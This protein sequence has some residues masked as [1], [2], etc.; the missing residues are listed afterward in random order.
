MNAEKKYK[1]YVNKYIS[2]YKNKIDNY[3]NK[4]SELISLDIKNNKP[5]DAQKKYEEVL[6]YIKSFKSSLNDEEDFKKELDNLTENKSKSQIEICESYGV[7]LRK[8]IEHEICNILLENIS[9]KII[10]SEEFN[11]KSLFTTNKDKLQKILTII[12]NVFSKV[13]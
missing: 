5:D 11:I 10:L 7:H 9:N 1:D 3:I 6:N 2:E 13:N 8:K 4:Q 12:V